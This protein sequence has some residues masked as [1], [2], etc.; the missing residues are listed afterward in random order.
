MDGKPAKKLRG[1]AV[2]DPEKRRAICSKGGIAASLRTLRA[3]RRSGI[4]HKDSEAA[5][6]SH[7][8]GKAHE[9]TSAEARIAGRKG[10]LANARR[11]AER[12]AIANRGLSPET[13]ALGA[14]AAAESAL[15][16][17]LELTPK[18]S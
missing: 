16:A 7:K 1:F 2:L 4:R 13:I 5:R 12:M 9:F 10:G 15:I 14:R 8:R 3:K 18:G 17:L 11:R 6:I